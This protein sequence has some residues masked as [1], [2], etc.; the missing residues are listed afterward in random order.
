MS[1]TFRFSPKPSSILFL[2]I[3]CWVVKVDEI[4]S[5]STKD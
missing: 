3:V 1:T 4:Y 5:T 2:Q